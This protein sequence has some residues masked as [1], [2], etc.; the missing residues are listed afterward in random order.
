MT[1]ALESKLFAFGYI[2][3]F[4]GIFALA[5]FAHYSNTSFAAAIVALIIGAFVTEWVRNRRISRRLYEAR[6]T[7]FATFHGTKPSLE[8]GS[9]HGFPYF[10]LTFRSEGE[11]NKAQAGG[12]I[13]SFKTSIQTLYAHYGH[14]QNPFD[15][16]KAVDVKFS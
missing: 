11:M 6:D 2:L 4:G 5:G 10:I 3:I 1:P 12:Q 7:A 16:E 8:E 13:D 9:A 14:K 15:A